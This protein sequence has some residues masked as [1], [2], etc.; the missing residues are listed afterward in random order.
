MKPAPTTPILRNL[1]R[2]DALG[3][4]RALVDLLQR[5]EQRADH[6]LRFRRLQDMAEIALFDLQSGVDRHLQAFEHALQD[7]LGRRV[8]VLGLAPQDG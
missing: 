7:R 6:R 2:L 3:A 8:V 5:D 4:A 1:G